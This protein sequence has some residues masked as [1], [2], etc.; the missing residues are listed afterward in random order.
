MQFP[1]LCAFKFFFLKRTIMGY[2]ELSKQQFN[3]EKIEDVPDLA[4]RIIELYT[5]VPSAEIWSEES[6]N[7]TIRQIEFYRQSNIFADKQILLKVYAQL[8]ELLNHIEHQAEIGMKFLYGHPVPHIA[9]PFDI[10]RNEV[11]IGDNSIYVKRVK[12]KSLFF[13]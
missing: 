13:S 12:G 8:E 9:A 10:Y 4:K 6:G 7:I 2:T 1:E 11:L 5:Q 3:G